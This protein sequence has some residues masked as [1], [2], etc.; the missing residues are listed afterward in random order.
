M[1]ED[2]IVSKNELSTIKGKGSIKRGMSFKEILRAMNY[3]EKEIDYLIE[4]LTETERKYFTLRYGKNFDCFN[5]SLSQV[6]RQ[7]VSTTMYNFKVNIPMRL[8]KKGLGDKALGVPITQDNKVS[9]GFKKKDS[10]DKEIEVAV[11]P[12]NTSANIK[13]CLIQIRDALNSMIDVIEE[14]EKVLNKT[15]K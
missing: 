14:K 10:E 4:N 6:E 5:T 7:R 2:T 12:S 15:K 13:S 8:A 11:I 9:D 1:S 3:T